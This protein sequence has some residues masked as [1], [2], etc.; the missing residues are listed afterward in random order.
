VVPVILELAPVTGPLTPGLLAELTEVYASNADYHRIS[1]DFPDPERVGP[2]QV[3]SA[4]GPEL[5]HPAAEVLLL[6]EVP[7]PPGRPDRLVGV[8]CVLHEHPDP[9]DPHPWIG[10]LLVRGDAQGRGYGRAAAG[11]LEDRFRAMG[12]DGARLAVLDGNPAALRF[13]T[14]L[15]YRVIDHRGDLHQGRPCSVLQKDFGT[16]D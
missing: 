15:G 7:E 1:G 10:L 11:L 16:A 5:E 6:R 2:E 13:W 3:A 8:A 12:R 4:L 9:L 14:G